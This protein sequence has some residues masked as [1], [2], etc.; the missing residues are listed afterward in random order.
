[1]ETKRKAYL[2]SELAK[3]GYKVELKRMPPKQEDTPT[4]EVQK[5]TV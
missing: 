5:I 2:K 1:M 4:G 3:L